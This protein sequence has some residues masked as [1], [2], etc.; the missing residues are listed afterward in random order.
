MDEWRISGE[1]CFECP[2]PWPNHAPAKVRHSEEFPPVGLGGDHS[3][4]IGRVLPAKLV[5]DA[6]PSGV[7]SLVLYVLM[8][9]HP[10]T[11]W[12]R[13]SLCGNT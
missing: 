7:Q 6:S 4:L 13:H 3:E 10:A 5:V 12:V 8:M 1:L 9:A 2:P 11:T